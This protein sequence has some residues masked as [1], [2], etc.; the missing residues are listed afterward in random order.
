MDPTMDTEVEITPELIRELQLDRES[1]TNDPNAPPPV[2][3]DVLEC[4]RRTEKPLDA[5][6]ERCRV[7]ARDVGERPS[8]E[9]GPEWDAFLEGAAFSLDEKVVVVTGASRGIGEAIA[10]RLAQVRSF[11]FSYGQ[12]V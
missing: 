12:L 2:K 8:A 5:A 11:L 1:D 3:L 7:V 4:L 10:I 9:L 6:L